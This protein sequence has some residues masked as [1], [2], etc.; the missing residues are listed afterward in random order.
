[1]DLEDL[2]KKITPRSRVLIIQHTFG[3]PAQ[4][5]ELLEIARK[6]NL[7]I[8]EDCAHTF[9]A[10]YAGKKLGTFGDIGMFSFGSDKPL[11]AV[12]GGALIT[13]D[14]QLGEKIKN[15][16]KNLS[17]GSLGEILRHLWH[18]PIFFVS[19]PLYGIG[20]GKFFLFLFGKLGI[21][22]KIIYPSEK[23]GEKTNF[24]P[25]KFSNALAE[26]L[27]KKMDETENINAKRQALAKI[28]AE[29]INNAKIK[30]PETL[31]KDFFYL[32]YPLIAEEPQALF[33]FAKEKGIILGNWYNAPIA[34]ADIDEK[35]TGYI[36]GSCPQAERLA[37]KSVNLPT[38]I[39]LNEEDA[40]GI[41]KVLNAY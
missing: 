16:Q 8:I 24:F 26:I 14:V 18:S 11:S 5:Q 30:M 33:A 28:Y 13:N 38:D 35:K 6:N 41:V 3:R 32:R 9:G 36:Q 21:I 22:N 39:N 25:A 7:K 27:L 10:K 23:R 29:G 2:Q 17:S 31:E 40:K 15:F 4:M 37:K 19:K 1:M 20:I 34:P 12:R